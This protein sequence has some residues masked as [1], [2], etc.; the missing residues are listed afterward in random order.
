M[1]CEGGKGWNSPYFNF[2]HSHSTT[3][4]HYFCRL[5][6]ELLSGVDCL[7][8]W[9]ITPNNIALIYLNPSNIRRTRQN[10]QWWKHVSSIKFVRIIKFRILM[11]CCFPIKEL[12]KNLFSLFYVRQSTEM[13]IECFYCHDYTIWVSQFHHIFLI[14]F[15]SNEWIQDTWVVIGLIWYWKELQRKIKSQTS[16]E[17]VSIFNPVKST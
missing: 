8:F 14:Y 6:Y 11:R 5:H 16:S 13:T 4:V 3:I 7:V 17:L 10:Y 1:K 12:T 15:R 2:I 9:H